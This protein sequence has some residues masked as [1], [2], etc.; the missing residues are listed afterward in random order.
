MR[1]NKNKKIIEEESPDPTPTSDDLGVLR[2][3]LHTVKG[4]SAVSTTTAYA[5]TDE[6]LEQ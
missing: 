6:T 1:L 3:L 2:V 4:I 5:P